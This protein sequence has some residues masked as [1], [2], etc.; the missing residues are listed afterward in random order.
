MMKRLKTMLAVIKTGDTV[1]ARHDDGN[2]TPSGSEGVGEGHL[3][4]TASPRASHL[5]ERGRHD[6]ARRRTRKPGAA[7][8][9]VH[10]GAPRSHRY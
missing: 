8:G 1:F 9:A 3:R 5:S 6:R 10:P 7:V 4:H 2:V